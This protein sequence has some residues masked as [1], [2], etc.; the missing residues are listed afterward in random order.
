MILFCDIIK[1]KNIIIH[2]ISLSKKD[3]SNTIES[4]RNLNDKLYTSLI[5]TLVK[6]DVTVCLENL[7]TGIGGLASGVCANPYEA[8]EMIDRYNNIAQKECFG[9]CLDMGHLNLLRQDCRHYIPILGR[10]IKA[11]HLHDNDGLSDQH[12]APY[13]GTIDWKSFCTEM[14]KINY[15]GDI[16]FETYMQTSLSVIDEEILLP[17]LSIIYKIGEHFKSKIQSKNS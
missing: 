8:V 17:W 7:F 6:T 15:C 14:A 11:L 9:L 4:I 13:T 16:S 5:S 10:R 2:G 12:K 1:C 3:K